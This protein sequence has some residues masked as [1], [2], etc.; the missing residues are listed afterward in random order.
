MT[1]ALFSDEFRSTLG[2]LGIVAGF[3]TAAIIPFGVWMRRSVINIV[4]SEVAPIR[5]QLAVVQR[6]VE[7]LSPNGGSHLRD[8]ITAIRDAVTHKP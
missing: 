5:T 7:Q 4:R 6:H 2:E 1:A 8:D 3:I